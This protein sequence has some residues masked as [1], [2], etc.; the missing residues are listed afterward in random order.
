MTSSP[1]APLQVVDLELTKPLPALPTHN[2]IGRRYTG[3]FCLLRYKGVAIEK[4][5]L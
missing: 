3:A 4:V 1:R 5:E 2:A